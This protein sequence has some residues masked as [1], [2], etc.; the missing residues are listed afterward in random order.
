MSRSGY[1]NNNGDSE[2]GLSEF[3]IIV[4]SQTWPQ[5]ECIVWRQ[6]LGSNK[7][8]LPY[9]NEWTIHGIWPSA[10]RDIGPASC[11][12]VKLNISNLKSM[13]KDLDIKWMNVHAGYNSESFWKHEWSKHGTCSSYLESV[14]DEIKY[15]QKG[16]DLYDKYNAK[17]ILD[18]LNIFPGGKYPVTTIL[19]GV[20]QVLGV[21][22]QIKC[23]KNMV[24]IKSHH[25]KSKRIKVNKS[26]FGRN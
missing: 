25:M 10:L 13:R 15:F 14:S 6:K 7:C 21:N 26:I 9:G 22:I 2:S 17:N 24:S 1:D 8:N 16:L 12:N 3:D 4:F 11:T 23:C 5:A 18:Q 20:R 19:Y